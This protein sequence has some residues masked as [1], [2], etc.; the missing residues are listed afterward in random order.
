MLKKSKLTLKQRNFCCYYLEAHGN[1]TEAVIKAGYGVKGRDGKINRILAKS[2]ASENL[3]KPY[4]IDYL[5]SLLKKGGLNDQMVSAQHAFLINQH[6]DLS[7]KM[8]A[9]DVYYKL[10]GKYTEKVETELQEEL[11]K[12]L[13]RVSALLPR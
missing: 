6:A 11:T 3:T 9:I 13:D 7:V 1:G 5:N 2:I 4:I 10:K 8:R 12:A